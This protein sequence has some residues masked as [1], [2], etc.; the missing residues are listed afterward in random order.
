MVVSA[1]GLAITIPFPFCDGPQ[2]HFVP[3]RK[4]DLGQYVGIVRF[5]VEIIDLF[6][7]F[8]LLVIVL[9]CFVL[10]RYS[11]NLPPL[12]RYA[13]DCAKISLSHG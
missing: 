1:N 13:V 11:R 7:S 8:V 6:D 12:C 5:L 9:I 10:R 4:H 2:R 3:F